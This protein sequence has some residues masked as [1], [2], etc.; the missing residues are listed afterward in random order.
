MTW[1]FHSGRTGVVAA[2]V[3]ALVLLGCALPAA[4]QAQPAAEPPGDDIDSFVRCFAAKWTACS[5]RLGPN[6]I[7][8]QAG[9]KG[10][11]VLQW[12]MF[13]V[14]QSLEFSVP[15]W[16]TGLTRISSDGGRFYFLA[17]R[18]GGAYRHLIEAEPAKLPRVLARLPALAQ[19]YDVSPD[20]TEVIFHMPVRGSFRC[21]HRLNVA[22]GE[23]R[24]WPDEN[25]GGLFPSYSPDGTQVAYVANK[26]LRVRD[27]ATAAERIVVDDATLKELPAWSPDG[28]WIA[29]QASADSVYSYEIYKVSVGTTAPLR[30]TTEPGIDANP[31]FSA[32]GSQILFVSQR[33]G[34]V[35]PTLF[36]M[37]ADGS[38]VQQDPTAGQMIFLPA[39]RGNY[40]RAK[41]AQATPVPSPAAGATP[42]PAP[43]LP[44]GLDQ[45][46]RPRPAPPGT[47][48]VQQFLAELAANREAIDRAL[49]GQHIVYVVHDG[50]AFQLKARKFGATEPIALVQLGD[51]FSPPC[52]VRTDA[53]TPSLVLRFLDRSTRM[54][55][56]VRLQR[57]TPPALL[58]GLPADPEL[59]FANFDVTADLAHALI[60]VKVD[61]ISNVF[62]HAV[63]TGETGVV[64]APD[65]GG[66]FP[67]LSPDGT[68]F[69]AVA[70][71]KLYT[72]DLRTGAERVLAG[73]DLLKQR[74]CWSPDGTEIVYEAKDTD[75]KGFDIYRVNVQTG[76]RAR[77]TEADGDDTCACVSA[78]GASILFVSER[79]H[80]RA[81]GALYRMNRDGSGCEADAGCE[82]GVL[83]AAW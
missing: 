55:W 6:T 56:L 75:D 74:P 78:D 17:S 23:S 44:A 12:K 81:K 31:C 29:Y 61:E 65:T 1:T 9:G 38:G 53:P 27:L 77:L 73:G 47:R 41:L 51:S 15:N 30:L 33:G 34:H 32:D 57:A 76:E 26:K 36:T 60:E 28:R 59:D 42:V 5:H 20:Q 3:A 80:G 64:T 70:N 54:N 16:F 50:A 62:R 68:C 2:V 8:C 10:G 79:G 24:P 63:A 72:R 45:P 18:H 7:A 14:P 58:A 13:G 40:P 83:A 71:G 37:N 49:D 22:T 48:T 19:Y 43:A 21:L 67:A 25:T 35:Q 69:A 52:L 66:V 11:W 39:G 46:A 4:A 82:T